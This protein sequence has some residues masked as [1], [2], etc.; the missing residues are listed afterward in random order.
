[1]GK[2][3]KMGGKKKIYNRDLNHDDLNKMAPDKCIFYKST[4]IKT[5]IFA[6]QII[7]F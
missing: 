2:L 5:T 1:M 6:V 3:I 7:N 4:I